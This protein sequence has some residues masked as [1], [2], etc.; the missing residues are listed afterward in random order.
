MNNIFKFL[1]NPEPFESSNNNIWIEGMLEDYTLNS[2]LDNNIPGGSPNDNFIKETVEF[3][4]LNNKF[5]K[6]KKV[7][8]LGCGPGLYAKK[9]AKKNYQVTGVDIS[10]KAINYAKKENNDSSIDYYCEDILNFN[11]TKKYDICLLIY[12]TFSTFSQKNREIILQKIYDSLENDGFLLLDVPSEFSFNNTM[13][14]KYWDSK[15][16]NNEFMKP[17]FF[18]F[19]ELKKYEKNL[20]LHKSI[21]IL[22][23]NQT[24]EFYDWYQ[25]FNIDALKCELMN[26]GFTQIE[27][28]SKTNGEAYE[29]ESGT[30]TLLCRK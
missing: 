17:S 25:H 8:D 9:L 1:K 11:I 6:G 27:V 15:D 20:L 7:L 2:Y 19:G 14:F 10:Q 28:Y 29:E 3:I 23:D 22:K 12:Q 18:M 13:N 24:L 16:E 4:N 26:H 5:S 30:I 21:Y